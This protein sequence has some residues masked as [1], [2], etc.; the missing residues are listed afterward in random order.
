MIDVSALLDQS[1]HFLAAGTWDRKFLSH[2]VDARLGD[3]DTVA[4]VAGQQPALGGGPLYTLAKAAQALAIAKALEAAGR[5]AVAVFWCA[6]EDHDL[7]EA[8]HADLLDRNGQVRR[9]SAEFGPGRASLRF[10]AADAGWP[11][12]M[13]ACRTHL[14]PG[15]GEAFWQALAPRPDEGLGAWQCRWLT[16]LLPGLA[17]VEGHCLRPTWTKAMTTAVTAWPAAE[18]EAHRQRLMTAGHPDPFGPL[19]SAPL[20]TDRITGRARLDQNKELGLAAQDDG[21]LSPGAALRPVLQ[22][23]ALPAVAAVLG[24]GERAYHQFILPLYAALDLPM[25]AFLPRRSV[26]W[27]PTWAERAARKRGLVPADIPLDPV[28]DAPSDDALAVA[29]EAWQTRLAAAAQSRPHLGAV[30]QRA[31]HLIDQTRR[32]LAREQRAQ[33]GRASPAQLAHWLHPRRQPQDRTMSCVQVIWEA[34]PAW[35]ERL[36]SAL[37]ASLEETAAFIS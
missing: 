25:P 36:T 24:P 11:E 33:S 3:P 21:L 1:H 2:H 31:R 34:G 6:S 19:L 13:A 37:G 22:Q 23:A 9:V 16:A 14:G 32:A 15:P 4:V 7:G 28:P 12:L 5:R 27:W 17:A 26:V 10:R 20:F 18:L 29:L 30:A 35:A 8:A